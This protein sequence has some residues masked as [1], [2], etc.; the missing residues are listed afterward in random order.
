M[1]EKDGLTAS[2]RS[3]PRLQSQPTDVLENYANK[4]NAKPLLKQKSSSINNYPRNSPVN[5][6][7]TF[8]LTRVSNSFSKRRPLNKYGFGISEPPDDQGGLFSSHRSPLERSHSDQREIKSKEN[9]WDN[10]NVGEESP[11]LEVK[12]KFQGVN[13]EVILQHEESKDDRSE[14]KDQHEETLQVDFVKDDKE[15][16]DELQKED[17]ILE[18]KEDDNSANGKLFCVFFI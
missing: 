6:E 17:I 14:K 9:T 7:T 13:E 15:D 1:S 16:K 12:T 18:N 8:D 11:P 2:Q 3:K 10:F 4:Y 5:G